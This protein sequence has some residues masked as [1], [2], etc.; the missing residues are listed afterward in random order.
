MQQ[1]NDRTSTLGESYPEKKLPALDLNPQPS[2][3]SSLVGAFTF[4]AGICST[5]Q[6]LLIDHKQAD[7]ERLRVEVI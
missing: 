1:L 3:L 6:K 4:I 5:P 7:P 2:Y